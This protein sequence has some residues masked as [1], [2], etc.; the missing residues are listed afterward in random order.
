MTRKY[1]SVLE[2]L[3]KTTTYLRGKDQFIRIHLPSAYGT[4]TEPNTPLFHVDRT[5]N[6]EMLTLTLRRPIL[7]LQTGESIEVPY[8]VELEYLRN[9]HFSLTKRELSMLNQMLILQIFTY[10]EIT[11]Q[12]HNLDEYLADLPETLE[13]FIQLIDIDENPEK[14]EEI[15][16]KAYKQFTPFQDA[17]NAIAKKH[18]GEWFAAPTSSLSGYRI[19][20][21]NWIENYSRAA[22]DSQTLLFMPLIMIFSLLELETDEIKHYTYKDYT[23]YVSAIISRQRELNENDSTNCLTFSYACTNQYHNNAT[24]DDERFICKIN[25]K[26]LSKMRDVINHYNPITISVHEMKTFNADNWGEKINVLL[27]DTNVI[28]DQ[29]EGG[30]QNV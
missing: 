23:K 25:T 27:N 7:G 9:S 3:N 22:C 28:W 1:I 10:H 8:I 24:N 20:Y 14:I 4:G 16:K 2:L 30:E 18:Q 19:I 15:V 26:I 6:E 21:N 11:I 13:P 5:Q 17:T 12:F 29:N